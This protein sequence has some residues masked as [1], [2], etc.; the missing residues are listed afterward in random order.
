MRFGCAKPQS[1]DAVRTDRCTILQLTHHMYMVYLPAFPSVSIV[2]PRC[3]LVNEGNDM[4]RNEF[5][6]YP[7]L[8]RITA[9]NPRQDFTCRGS[10]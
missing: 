6:F 5:H 7:Q 10:F 9:Q 3:Q 2:S 4:N 1:T 8:F